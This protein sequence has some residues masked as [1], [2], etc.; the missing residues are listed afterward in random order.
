M[1]VLWPVFATGNGGATGWY[2][3]SM[4]NVTNNSWRL[5]VPTGF[6]ILLT[7]YVLFAMNEEYR[8]YLDLR[9]QYLA[10]GDSDD[11]NPQAQHSVMVE[12]LPKE[13]RSDTA[14]KSYF[15]TVFPGKVHSASVVLNI[16]E[17][18]KISAKRKRTARRL[19]KSIAY[20]KATGVRGTHV[21]GRKRCRFCGIETFPIRSFGG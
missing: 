16:P 9:M 19:E 2:Y 15:D 1:I 8:H 6:M 12:E 5:W 3:F 21:V 17:L 20:H 13:L 7:I 10:E 14:L 18:E 11:M 4:A